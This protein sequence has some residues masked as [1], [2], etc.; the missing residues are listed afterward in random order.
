MSVPTIPVIERPI[1][2]DPLYVTTGTNYTIPST[3]PYLVLIQPSAQ[4]IVI[5]VSS[6][7]SHRIM[8]IS[9]TN[10]L[11]VDVIT[12]PNVTVQPG[13]G[14][15]AIWDSTS[16]LH[17]TWTWNTAVSTSTSSSDTY[18]TAATHGRTDAEIGRP[19]YNST[20]FVDTNIEHWPT[21]VLLQ[22]ISNDVLKIAKPGD[23]ITLSTTLLS[24][25]DAMNLTLGRNVW[26]D[27]SATLYKQTRMADAQ[28]GVPAILYI[29]AIDTVA[30]TFTAV[31]RPLVAQPWRKLTE[32]TL[33]GTD[34]T[35][36]EC[37]LIT[38]GIAMDAMVWFNGVLVSSADATFNPLTGVLDW[39]GLALDG[40]AEAGMKVQ[41]LYEPLL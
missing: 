34:V 37:A 10:R 40:Q 25:G 38:A 22:K 9:T 14:L 11:I 13:Q 31:V 6:G 29:L 35:N 3:A 8:N 17:W 28:P 41:G 24:G 36:K 5:T 16:N 30:D 26:W 23:C 27:N 4:D 33:T 2:S 21:S 32:Y 39:D 1:V 7:K 18:L 15:D 12:A 19:L 20:I